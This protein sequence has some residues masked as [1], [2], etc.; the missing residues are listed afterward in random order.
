MVDGEHTF[1]HHASAWTVGSLRRALN[2]VPDNL[3]VWVS[4]AEKP[5]GELPESEY[6]VIKAEPWYDWG[7][8]RRPPDAFEI[9]CDYPNGEYP[10]E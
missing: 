8:K 7:D 10:V 4:V 3:V 1:I 6:V 9:G 5:G 2:G